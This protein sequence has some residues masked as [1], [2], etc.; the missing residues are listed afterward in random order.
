MKEL[1]KRNERI[2]QFLVEQASQ[3]LEDEAQLILS[4]A[5]GGVMPDNGLENC[6]NN[7]S[8]KNL[9]SCGNSSNRGCTN[10]GLVCVGSINN[11][12]TTY[13]LELPA[14]KT[15][16]CFTTNVSVATCN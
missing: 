3:A 4:S 8:C 14:N 7:I 16:T 13:E 2:R 6:A 1:E 5:I 12:C 15:T 11:E 10:S 9:S